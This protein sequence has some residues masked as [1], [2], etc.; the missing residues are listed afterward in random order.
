MSKNRKSR[1]GSSYD[2]QKHGRGP[3]KVPQ[4]DKTINNTTA[5]VIL[6]RPQYKEGPL[7]FRP[8]PAIWI[9][10]DGKPP[11]LLRGRKNAEK[12]G[13]NEFAVRARVVSYW[14]AS[15]CPQF[16][17]I[18]QGPDAGDRLRR[19]NPASIFWFACKNAFDNDH[20]RWRWNS[21]MKGSKKGGAALSSPNAFWYFQGAVYANGDTDYLSDSAKPLGLRKDDRLVVIQA[22]G[23]CCDKMFTLFDQQLDNPPPLDAKRP[24]YGSQFVCGDPTGHY[25]RA[26]GIVTGGRL[27]AVYNPSKTKQVFK[28]TTWDGSAPKT[29]IWG[30]EA[31]ILQSYTDPRGNKHRPDLD[32]ADVKKIFDVAEFFWDY[33]DPETGVVDKGL[34]YVPSY[35]EQV[36]MIA[37]A[38]ATVPHMVELGFAD[39]PELLTGDIRSILKQAKSSV[40]AAEAVDEGVDDDDDDGDDRPVARASGRS[41]RGD[42]EE[43]DD[44]TPPRGKK[45]GRRGEEDD[46]D[47]EAVE[48]DD[49][50]DDEEEEEDDDAPPRGK[51][52]AR[53]EEEEGDEDDEEEE[54]DDDSPPRGKKQ[55][56]AE[57][58]DD[59]PADSDVIPVDEEGDEFAADVKPRRGAAAGKGKPKAARDDDP[60]PPDGDDDIALE[61]DDDAPS[62]SSSNG[63]PKKSVDPIEAQFADDDDD[64]PKKAK[65]AR[66]RA[67][68]RA[69]NGGTKPAIPGKATGK[70]GNKSSTSSG[71]AH[72]SKKGN[73]QSGRKP[74]RTGGRR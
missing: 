68:D 41:R 39:H 34:L 38:F 16:T 74:A 53:A 62:K 31:A 44:D 59:E 25:N 15:G 64:D 73:T 35:E 23:A 71:S 57:E 18:L 66:D 32:A 13:F 46:D 56:R 43:D 42:D 6:L 36:T 9:E 8:F 24:D 37:R 45:R 47:V 11:K 30:Y 22:K 10:E 58:D 65:A 28:R 19:D 49:G 20:P 69:R 27:L 2:Q 12:L 54:D 7:Y 60:A 70:N 21:L 55:A 51:K 1:S 61:D 50:G 5:E 48:Y 17:W 40:P 33:K 4:D 72:G 63:K 3:A 52:P 67:L 29:G 14:G 26:E